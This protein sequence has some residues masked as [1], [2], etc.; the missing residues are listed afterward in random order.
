MNA[1][2][3]RKYIKESIRQVST[4][5]FREILTVTDCQKVV[6]TRLDALNEEGR[7]KQQ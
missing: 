4:A 2:L 7:I 3:Q 1:R 6:V 5:I